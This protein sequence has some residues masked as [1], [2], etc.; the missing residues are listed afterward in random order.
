MDD[1]WGAT[2]TAF[3]DNNPLVPLDTAQLGAV[4]QRCVAKLS[5]YQF[6]IK[7]RPGVAKRMLMSCLEFHR[8]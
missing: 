8:M 5:N 1:L 4:E 3:T 7:Y 2:F 6:T